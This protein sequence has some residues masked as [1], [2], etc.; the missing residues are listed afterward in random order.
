MAASVKYGQLVVD[1]PEVESTE[2]YEERDK[3]FLDANEILDDRR[4]SVLLS[5]IGASHFSLLSNLLAP[6][7]PSDKTVGEFLAVLKA[8]FSKKRVTIAERYRFYNRVQKPGES[9]TQFAAS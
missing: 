8:H 7:K 9:A 6:K 2:L 1:Q 4:V 5:V 3:V